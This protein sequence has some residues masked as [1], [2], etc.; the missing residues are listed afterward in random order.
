MAAL[1]VCAVTAALVSGRHPN[2]DGDRRLARSGYSFHMAEEWRVSVI[3]AGR[4]ARK[5]HH[6]IQVCALLRSGLGEDITVSAGKLHIFMYAGT[7]DAAEEAEHVARQALAQLGLSEDCRLERWDTSS[8]EWLEVRSGLP[9]AD[10]ADLGTTRL[11]AAAGKVATNLAG[12]VV[13]G[14]IQGN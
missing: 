11:R 9:T 6:P 7:A 1:A 4:G 5:Y 14:F 10:E 8:Q 13:E 3:F 2:R 12:A